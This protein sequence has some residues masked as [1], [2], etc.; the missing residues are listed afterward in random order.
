MRDNLTIAILGRDFSWG[1]GIDFLRAITNALVSLSE[2]GGHRVFLLLPV[3]NKRL[4]SLRER[5]RRILQTLFNLIKTGKFDLSREEPLFDSSFLNYFENIDGKIEVVFY[6]YTEGLLPILRRIN[7]DVV[8]PALVSL[9][10]DFPL[11]WIGY[12]SDFQHKYFPQNF[13]AKECLERDILFARTLLDAKTVIV[14]SKMTKIDIERFYPYHEC[15]IISLPFSPVPI[16]TWLENDSSDSVIA[17]YQIPTRYFLISN[18]FWKHKSHITAFEAL[19]LLKNSGAFNDVHIVCTGKMEDYRFPK[20]VSELRQGARALGL[21]DR[22]H[23][24]GQIPKKD[25]IDIMKHS[26][27]LLQPTL[28]EGGAGGGS[29]YDAVALGVPVI[30]SDILVNR[31]VDSAGVRFFVAGAADDMAQKMSAILKENV[32]RPSR[33]ALIT[34]GEVRRQTMGLCL[35]E[36]I[37]YVVAMKDTERK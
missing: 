36:A 34:Q 22:I 17:K 14:N 24:L 29:V 7:A 13:T 21:E 6:D 1:G 2:Y 27:A 28:F 4:V 19:A 37:N 15:N 30:L 16:S 12:I 10:H 25:Q 20:Y 3:K 26:V 32:V 11:P 31:E 18:Q 5:T 23:F 8:L 33:D 35:L 9:G